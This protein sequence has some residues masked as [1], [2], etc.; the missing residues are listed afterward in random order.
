VLVVPIAIDVGLGLGL[1][2]QPFVMSAVIAAST[3]FLMPIGHQ[4]NIIIFGAGGYKFFDFTRVGV[5]LNL[6]LLAVT[7]IF[8]PLIWPF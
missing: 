1:N 4:V 8:V 6:L 2:P 5:G 3:S 7:A